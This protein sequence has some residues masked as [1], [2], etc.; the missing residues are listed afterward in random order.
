MKVWEGILEYDESL[1]SCLKWLITAS[2]KSPKGCI[3]GRKMPNDYWSIGYKGKSRYAHR[4]VWEIHYGE[5]PDGMQID[6]ID[7]NKRNNKISNLR[8]VTHK[9]NHQNMP[10]QKNNSSGITGVYRSKYKDGKEFWHGFWKENGKNISKAFSI[11]KY[12]EEGAK[13][14]AIKARRDA[15]SKLNANGNEYTEAH[16]K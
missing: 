1:E 3:A 5:I 11:K 8:L 2:T 7:K 15:L 14:M 10:M 13:E 12:G 9:S 16:G 6:H 4:I